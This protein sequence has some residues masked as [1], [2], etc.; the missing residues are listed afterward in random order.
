MGKKLFQYAMSVLH[1]P[2]RDKSKGIEK[3]WHSLNMT[4]YLSMEHVLV[5][6]AAMDMFVFMDTAQ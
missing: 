3:R 6:I 4:A 2:R 5:D 1:D